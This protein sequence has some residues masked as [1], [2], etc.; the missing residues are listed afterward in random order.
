MTS[1]YTIA[2]LKSDWEALLHGTSL[3]DIQNPN[4]IINRAARD[5]LA[6]C[7]FMETKRVSQFAPGIFDKDTG[8]YN[9]LI[10]ADLKLNKVIDIR[11]Q[12]NRFIGNNP[13]Q[14][15][16]KEFDL[17]KAVSS[18]SIDMDTGLKFIRISV[19][20]LPPAVFND[21]EAVTGSNGTNAADGVIATS[22]N[23]D[24]LYKVSGSASLSFTLSGAG[25]GT[26][27]NSTLSS[28]DLLS[29]KWSGVAS[30][31]L[32]VYIPANPSSL[33]SVALKWGSSASAYWSAS[34]TSNFWSQAFV[35]GWNLLE[36][37]WPVTSTGS[38]D[39]SKLTYMQ[40][41]FT[42]TGSAQT[43]F[44]VD[45]MFFAL[46]TI[47]EMVYYSK[48]I[49]QNASGSWIETTSNDTDLVNLDTDSYNILLYKCAELAGLQVQQAIPMRGK[50]INFDFSTYGSMYD[51]AVARYKSNY[52][53]EV[54]KVTGTYYRNRYQ[55][56]R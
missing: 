1:T 27:T 55:R 10:P 38:P 49:F 56:N 31:F 3:S 11:P 20:G 51:A 17:Y 39:A 47:Y 52:R 43:N 37:T 42:W 33:T 41:S 7:D 19:A 24:T 2:Q 9:Y 32:W 30:V 45:R 14:H 13:I 25:T 4:D 28:T 6:D 29:T 21:F 46:P 23:A 22:L 16:S 54:L 15:A 36:F 40:A 50:M 8:V 53:S 12:V 26:I 44:R 34:A 18:I 5:C 48:Y 35:T